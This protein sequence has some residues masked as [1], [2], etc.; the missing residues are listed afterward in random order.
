MGH[1]RPDSCHMRFQFT[2][3]H[4]ILRQLDS[5]LPGTSHHK[6]GAC[7][8]ADFFQTVQTLFPVFQR[9]FRRGQFP[10][11]YGMLQNRI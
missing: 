3:K 2:D 4:H 10:A 8:K 9:Q 7:L 5:G 6:S 1:K 11:D